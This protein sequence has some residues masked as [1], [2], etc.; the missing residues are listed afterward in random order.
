MK[1]EDGITVK[2]L[3]YRK[4]N[5]CY[6]IPIVSDCGDLIGKHKMSARFKINKLDRQ[7]FDLLIKPKF[8]QCFSMKLGIKM[9]NIRPSFD[10]LS[11][12]LDIPFDENI[13]R[14]TLVN[15]IDKFVIY[16]KGW[17]RDH[18]LKQILNGEDF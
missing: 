16:D 13:S 9:K 5:V 4:L 7:N 1:S 6:E 2:R 17:V 3:S 14:I 10:N 12:E 11:L 18:K 8:W 15:I